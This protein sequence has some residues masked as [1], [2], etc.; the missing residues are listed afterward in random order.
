MNQHN[1]K[2]E[3]SS[4][5]GVKRSWFQ[6]AI[7][8]VKRNRISILFA[9]HLIIF[10]AIFWLALAIRFETFFSEERQT[11]FLYAVPTV[12]F[13][14]VLI[15]FCLRNFHGWWRN[16]TFSD[17]VGVARATAI[18][19]VALIVIDYFLLPGF[20][21]PRSVIVIDA[22][23][24]VAVLSGLRSMF[25]LWDENLAGLG[26]KSVRH[27]A[28]IV[29]CNEETAKLG[30]LINS[31]RKLGIRIVGMV[32]PGSAWA[33]RFSDLKVIG[34]LDD[35]PNLA[36]VYRAKMIYVPHGLLNGKDLRALIETA[37]EHRLKIHVVP[38]LSSMLNRGTELPLRPV[39]FEDLLKRDEV[40]L[41]TE[42]IESL[43]NNQSVL[44]T[45]AGGSIGSEICRQLLKF[46]P[47]KLVLLGRGENRLYHLH[48]E[49]KHLGLTTDLH[50]ELVNV[51]DRARLEQV[52][53]QHRPK[54]VFHAAAH[55]HV[56]L[57]EQNV[58]EAVR[59]NV[60]GSKLVAQVA[61]EFKCRKFVLVSTDKAVNP[62]SV[63][64]CTKQLAERFCL[65]LDYDSETQFIVTRF[66]NVLGSEGSVVP[67]FKEQIRRGGPITV[68]HENI[69]RY[70]MTIPEAAQLVLQ[71]STMGRGGEIFVLEMGQPVKIVDLARD[72]IRLAGQP[73][74]SIEIVFS[75]MRPGEKLHEELYFGEEK[76]M[77]TGH[78]KILSA[79]CRPIVPAEVY[80][81]TDRIIAMQND[82][83]FQIRA[84][85][86]R[87]IP[88][89]QPPE[90]LINDST[91]HPE[92]SQTVSSN[93]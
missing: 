26:R 5:P 79:Y 75:G 82:D 71:A 80:R 84:E 86:K 35:L 41:D 16:V 30:H 63:M 23:L 28:L 1:S 65:A 10:S 81:D 51:T 52:F 20:Q 62:S 67:L 78:E 32:A 49:L 12:A 57:L 77:E 19:A 58:G 69:T 38:Q 88:E 8:T 22:A 70:F 44:V 83:E 17:L 36:H 7:K 55:K 46:K 76:P 74:D 50:C 21:I 68:T 13:L 15:F 11:E 56:P 31:R 59:N 48:K 93:S 40:N 14:K 27:R 42:A 90:P 6:T 9:A 34:E 61:A 4:C 37:T 3:L 72:L 18:A 92:Q 24:S 53:A 66:G 54:I 85:L 25:R 73:V 64:G 87:Q 60:L 2:Q 89:Y 45:G 43:V 33:S 29:G 47:A 91:V 39:R